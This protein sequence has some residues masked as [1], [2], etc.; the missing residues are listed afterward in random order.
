[1]SPRAYTSGGMKGCSVIHAALKCHVL[2]LL[3]RGTWFNSLPAELQTSLVD[4]SEIREFCAHQ[5]VCRQGQ[6]SSGLW[7]VLDGQVLLE[8]VF[9]DGSEFLFHVGGPG[10]WFGD[11]GL[12]SSRPNVVTVTTATPARILLFPAKAFEALMARD[13]NHFRLFAQLTIDRF[14]LILR[15]FALSRVLNPERYCRT[16]LALLTRLWREDGHL[17]PVL[18]ITLSQSTVA[19]LVGVSRQTLNRYLARLQADQTVETSFRTLRILEPE[20]L[21]AEELI[22]HGRVFDGL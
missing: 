10:H 12:L 14:Q 11:L 18:E 4:Q 5:S 6:P 16:R 22:P 20:R 9:E 2:H 7:A 3:R 13:P 19:R 17:G 8:A 1:M 21:S 15:T